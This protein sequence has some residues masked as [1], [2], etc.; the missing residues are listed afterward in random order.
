MGSIHHTGSVFSQR[1]IAQD[2]LVSGHFVLLHQV[3][4]CDFVQGG[5]GGGVSPLCAYTRL[6]LPAFAKIVLK[7]SDQT[8]ATSAHHSWARC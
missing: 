4:V 6:L 7:T 2:G 8:R 5:M 1:S 3:V